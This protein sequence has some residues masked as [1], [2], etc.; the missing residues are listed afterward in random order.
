MINHIYQR[1]EVADNYEK[2]RNLPSSLLHR[3]LN[4]IIVRYSLLNHKKDINFFEIGVGTGTLSFPIINILSSKANRWFFYGVDNSKNMLNIFIKKLKSQKFY[5]IFYN[6]IDVFY[7]DIEKRTNLPNKKFDLILLGGVLHCLKSPQMTLSFLKSK[8]K[9]NGILI[10]IIQPDSFIKMMAGKYEKNKKY[11]SQNLSNWVVEFWKTYHCYRNEMNIPIDKR[12]E[13][14]YSV[15]KVKNI[16]NSIKG[17]H[18]IGSEDLVWN[19][20]IS[21]NYFIRIIR[22][23]LFLPIGQNL[24]Q[25]N[26]IRL[27]NKMNYWVSKNIINKNSSILYIRRALL[28]KRT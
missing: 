3:W 26:A 14:I 17:L 25:I 23:R 15:K 2:S 10:I 13:L 5:K 1:K 20:H 9:K 11:D 8:L 22:K 27:A 12:S 24:S 19:R 4:E 16:V 6:R 21:P 7:A 28:W 18:Y